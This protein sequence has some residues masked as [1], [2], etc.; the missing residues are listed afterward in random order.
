MNEDSKT[1]RPIGA[2]LFVV[3]FVIGCAFLYWAVEY[4]VYNSF[5]ADRYELSKI[6]VG[7]SDSLSAWKLDKRTGGLEYCAKSNDKMDR[8]V[9]VRSTIIDAKDYSRPA[10]PVKTPEANKPTA[11]ASATTPAVQTA[12]AIVNKPMVESPAVKTKP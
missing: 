2:I 9:C 4:W 8:F 6:Q 3:C 10:E 1:Q 11:E 5:D 7:N 12:P